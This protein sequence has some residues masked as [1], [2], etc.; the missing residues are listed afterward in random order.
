ML[1]FY[2]RALFE[3]GTSLLL[4]LIL[5][6]FDWRAVMNG[7][8][9]FEREELC[10]SRFEEAGPYFHLYT[11][12]NFPLIFF[13]DEQY[14]N[15]VSLLALC[16]LASEGVVLYAFCFMSNHLHLLVCGE[17]EAL[18]SFFAMFRKYF[19]PLF[20]DVNPS[21][22]KLLQ[23]WELSIKEVTTLQQFRNTLAYIHRNPFVV[24]PDFTPFTYP[25]S[26][27]RAAF[28]P[29][30]YSRNQDTI[31][32]SSVR[33]ARELTK[34]RQFEN[35]SKKRIVDGHISIFEFCDIQFVESVFTS[36]REYF[37]AHIKKIESEREF[38]QGLGERISRSDSELSDI[39]DE[40]SFRRYNRSIRQLTNE[41]MITMARILRDRYAATNKQLHRILGVPLEVI[42]TMY[43]ISAQKV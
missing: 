28:S 35:I 20:E 25:W 12:E 16:V 8:R 31:E 27:C 7:M 36:A 5:V 40:L 1:V 18:N 22:S 21:L 26:S 11:S 30:A 17:E 23:E 10:S 43:P 42:D 13:N 2:A 3:C 37:F 32:Y 29:D 14:A 24:D 33:W 4:P 6:Y 41:Q 34:S 15:A 39:V 9:R 38:T 19:S